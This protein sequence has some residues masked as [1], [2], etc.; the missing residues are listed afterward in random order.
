MA[1]RA[2]PGGPAAAARASRCFLR[3]FPDRVA[4]LVS[5]ESGR[6]QLPG[7]KRARLDPKS[8]AA[9]AP[10]ICAGQALESMR[11]TGADITLSFA[12]EIK[13]DWLREA[14]P[15]DIK[16][17][18]RPAL[19]KDML[20][21][22]TETLTMYRDIVLRTEISSAA[23]GKP[24]S[25]LIAE[26]FIS[27]RQKFA[28]WNEDVED[29]LA[30]VEFLSK[31]CPDLGLQPPG[32]E[33]LKLII[34]DIC[35]GAKSVSDAKSRPVLPAFQDWFGHQAARNIDRLAPRRLEMPGGRRA[36][37]VYPRGGEP[38]LEAKI[39]DIFSLKDTPRIA[40]GR[41]PLVVHILAP[42]MRPVQVTKDL[43]SFWAV[44][45]PK[46][47]PALARRYPKHKWL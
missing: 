8:A 5:R 29:F 20:S 18:S 10:V 46:L 47:K 28:A 45:Y 15:G 40:G 2:V 30:R 27:G 16:I 17:V 41:V 24:S 43:K 9:G 42:S 23:K 12:A 33:D 11:R 35:A 38:Y 26:E 37:I 36:K 7:G 31:A 13:E 19:D 44:S 25:D 14:F 34:S 22:V 39:Q 21:P 1:G 32:E 3:A 4:A 6:Y